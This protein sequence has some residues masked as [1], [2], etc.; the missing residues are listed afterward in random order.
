VADV[1]AGQ[2]R[3]RI[4]VLKNLKGLREEALK[5]LKGLRVEVDAFED[6]GREVWRV[7]DEK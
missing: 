1:E 6:E 2:K 3:P 7:N 4:E 5:S